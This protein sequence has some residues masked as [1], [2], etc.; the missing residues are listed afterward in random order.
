MLVK[1]RSIAKVKSGY[2]FRESLDLDISGNVYVLQSKKVFADLEIGDNAILDQINLNFKSRDIFL[3]YND[4]VFVSKT[5]HQADFRSAVFK[6]KK[7]NVTFSNTM[8]SV[9]VESDKIVPEYLSVYLNSNECQKELQKINSYTT[10]K[11]I[12]P[13][14]LLDID[15]PIP[16]IVIQENLIKLKQNI[17]KQ[18]KINQRKTE[19]KNQIINKTLTNIINKNT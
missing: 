19:L 14:A 7:N 18:E 9:R 13:S 8:I 16:P 2:S 3:K 12:P 1:L 5:G 15:I 6:S 11:H 10:I 4:I 17:N